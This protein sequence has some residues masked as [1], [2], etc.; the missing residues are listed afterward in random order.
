MEESFSKTKI[1]RMLQFQEEDFSNLHRAAGNENIIVFIGAGVAKLYGCLLWNEMATKLAEILL[2]E[3]LIN[4]AENNILAIEA[5]EN[6]RKVISICHTLCKDKLTIYEKGIKDSITNINQSEI[7]KIY[8]KIFSLEA[9]AY[10]TTN[11]DDGINIYINSYLPRNKIS[12][13]KEYNCT[14]ASDQHTIEQLNYNIF[15]D[16]N[17]VYL[18]GNYM[19][20]FECILPVEKYLDFYNERNDF[21]NNLFSY[22]KKTDCF[23]VFI[24]YGLNEWDIIE[25]IYKLRSNNPVQNVGLLLSPIFSHEITKFTLERKYYESFGVESIPYIIDTTGYKELYRVLDNIAKALEEDIPS[26]YEL[27]KEIEEA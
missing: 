13:P 26:P 25:R 8:E 4:Y 2:N 15:K 12:I 14:S 5:N 3:G 21:V 18:H 24:G 20:I 19:N 22:L 27:I 11:I 6:S 1:E 17:V 9:R 16:G 7:G 10:L 23:I